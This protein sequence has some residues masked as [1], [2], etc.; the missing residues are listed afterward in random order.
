VSLV[1]PDE[2]ANLRA[3]E[4]F[5]GHSLPSE[6][7]SGFEP[8]RATP[9]STGARSRS[10]ARQAPIQTSRAHPHRPRPS[11]ATPGRGAARRTGPSA[12][13]EPRR[14]QGRDGRWLAREFT[15][16]EARQRSYS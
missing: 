14:T 15:R 10:G 7:V 12:W 9:G 2:T 4:R 11:A 6:V 13:P 5:L 8:G 3:V 1:S 16:Q